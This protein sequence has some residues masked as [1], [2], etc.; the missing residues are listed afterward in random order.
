VVINDA[1]DQTAH[2]ESGADIDRA[3]GTVDVK[4]DA[5]REAFALAAGASIGGV[6]AGAAV[7]V[8]DIGGETKAY[9]QG[10]DIGQNISYTVNDVNVQAHSEVDAEVIS[11]G[12][13]AGVGQ[14]LT[15]ILPS[16]R[17]TRL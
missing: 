16:S 12:V 15:Q 11:V 1:S 3:G 17:L 6:C 9:L 5:N 8:V 2:I 7:T 4:A 14:P 13:K 10:A